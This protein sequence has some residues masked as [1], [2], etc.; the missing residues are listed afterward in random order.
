MAAAPK[1]A[2]DEKAGTLK[3]NELRKQI[4]HVERSVMTLY[5]PPRSTCQAAALLGVSIP[6]VI[7]SVD[8]GRLPGIRLGAAPG[9]KNGRVLVLTE[10]LDRLLNGET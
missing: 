10:P 3:T 4:E 8:S 5:S 6:T 2:P 1:T 9:C 7:E